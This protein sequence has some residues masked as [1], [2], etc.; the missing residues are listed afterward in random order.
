MKRIKLAALALVVLVLVGNALAFKVKTIDPA[1]NIY[2]SA[3]L[4]TQFES[5]AQQ[6]FSLINFETTYIGSTGNPCIGTGVDAYI[7]VADQCRPLGRI[8]W[9]AVLPE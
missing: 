1:A 9:I 6:G 4:P 7:T 3:I 2:C 5:C 8:Q